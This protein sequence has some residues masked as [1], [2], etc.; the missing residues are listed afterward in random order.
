[1]GNVFLGL[2]IQLSQ[3]VVFTEN[4]S[5]RTVLGT[6]NTN[7]SERSLNFPAPGRNALSQNFIKRRGPKMNEN[8]A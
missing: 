5:D 8:L 1:M 3:L 4:T 6:F 7:N 2:G